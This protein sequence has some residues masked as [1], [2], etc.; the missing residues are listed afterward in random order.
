MLHDTLLLARCEAAMIRQAGLSPLCAAIRQ[1]S[2]VLGLAWLSMGSQKRPMAQGRGYEAM[3]WGCL[4]LRAAAGLGEQQILSAAEGN[5]ERKHETG[6]TSSDRRCMVRIW[7]RRPKT[8]QPM[9]HCREGGEGRPVQVNTREHLKMTTCT[10]TSQQL[11][12][13]Y[14]E[15]TRCFSVPGCIPVGA[16]SPQQWCHTGGP[17]PLCA[18]Q[19]SSS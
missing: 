14:Q 17:E 6:R 15:D 4:V 11:D 9:G 10:G 7:Y 1:C 19:A 3:L 2:P 12:S 13:R 8:G 16:A 18:P 5:R